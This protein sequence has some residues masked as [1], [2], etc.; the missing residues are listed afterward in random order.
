MCK[1][2]KQYGDWMIV[3]ITRDELCESYLAIGE[4]VLDI[5]IQRT[6][7]TTITYYSTMVLKF[8]LEWRQLTI[9]FHRWKI[10]HN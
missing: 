4:I 2:A 5:T 9:Q 7:I 6:D 8:L 3:G 1:Q 10:V